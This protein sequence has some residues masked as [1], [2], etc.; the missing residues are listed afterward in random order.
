MFVEEGIILVFI[1]VLLTAHEQHVLQVVGKAR[2]LSRVTKAANT[3]SKRSSSLQG[4][5][6]QGRVCPQAQA[7]CCRAR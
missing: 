2:K 6:G 1:W 5:A 3:N 4:G 7:V